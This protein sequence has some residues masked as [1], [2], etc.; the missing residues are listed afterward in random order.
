MNKSG[1]LLIILLLVGLKANA[2]GLLTKTEAIRLIMSHNFDVV[3]SEKNIDIAENNNSIY[4]SG[5]LP[6]LTGSANIN[7]NR[8]NLSVVTQ[9]GQENTLS[10]AKSDS[11]SAGINLNYVLF[12]G[13]NRKYNVA[14][15]AE[16]LNRSQLNARATLENTLI[17]L[18]TAYYEVARAQQDLENLKETLKISKERLTRATYGFDYGRNTRLDISNAQ[19]DVNTDSI[20]YLNAQQLLANTRHNLNFLLGRNTTTDFLVDTTLHFDTM[21]DKDG[22]QQN[23]LK[24]NVQL[25]LAKSDLNISKYD[26]RISDYNYL[27]T[28]SLTSG[29]NYRKNNNNSASF[30][31]SNTSSGVT[32]GLNL[33]WNIFDGGSSRTNLQN[34]KINEG[35]RKLSL[36]QSEQQVQLNFENA[37]GDYQNKLFIVQ[38]QEN[39][40]KTNRLNF[41]RTQEQYKLGRISSIDFRTSQNNL[42]TAAT[43]LTRARYDAKLA[44]LL[45]LQLAGLIQSADF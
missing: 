31:A 43:S 12:D 27:P 22:L 18:F 34:A 40:L 36:E 41:E 3:I 20:N 37:W 24:E 19:V 4:N 30:T 44:E 2:Q 11:R 39:N 28:V 8:D 7:F 9:S 16:N 13:F 5:Y 23:M 25:L 1:Y 6:T 33:G 17:S 45:L 21:N 42:L 10:G 38:A 32:A 14:R 35:I 29:Y 26:T 15:N